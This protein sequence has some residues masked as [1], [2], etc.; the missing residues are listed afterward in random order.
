MARS[1]QQELRRTA[2]KVLSIQLLLA[3][4]LAFA[5][6]QAEAKATGRVAPSGDAIE[7]EYQDNDGRYTDRIPLYRSGNVRYFSAGV[8]IE[9]RMAE[10]PNFSLKVILAAG[11][12]YLSHVSVSIENSTGDVRV[13]IPQE[14]V[15]GPWLFVDLPTGT[16]RLNGTKDGLSA[17]TKNAEVDPGSQKTVYLRW[18]RETSP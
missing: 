13:D 14:R 10:Y 11:S 8:G 5:C 17:M 12:A 7:L 18:P 1:D 6:A 3:A 4:F 16:Y 9:E 15:T 2:K